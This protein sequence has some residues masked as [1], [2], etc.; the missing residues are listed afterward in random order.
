MNNQLSRRTLAKG[1][2]WAAPVVAASAVVPAYASSQCGTPD[3]SVNGGAS[4]QFGTVA[5]SLAD[6][7]KTDMQ[8]TIG[9]QPTVKNLPPGVTVTKITEQFFIENH[10]GQNTKGNG[11][12]FMGNPSTNHYESG[13][14]TTVGCS[15]T[16]TYAPMT[17]SAQNPSTAPNPGWSNIVTNTQNNQA[18]TYPGGNT[19]NAWD[20]TLTWTDASG[21]GTYTPTSNGCREFTAGPSGRFAIN[22]FNVSRQMRNSE[23]HTSIYATAYLSNGTILTTER[24]GVVVNKQP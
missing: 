11:L 18:T 17:P 24:L 23:V 22:Y 15:T 14:C 19:Y 20:A 3:F 9:A 21:S 2:A 8:L 1:A 4:V 5:T 13:K 12:W 7:G 10:Q 6:T 16:W